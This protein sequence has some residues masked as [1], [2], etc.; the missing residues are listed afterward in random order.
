MKAA[1]LL[2]EGDHLV[3]TEGKPV[4]VKSITREKA[5]REV[6][7]FAVSANDQNMAEHIIAAEGVL[8]GDLVWQGSLSDEEK[9][10]KLR[11]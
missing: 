9:A 4:L 7:N 8:V 1:R 3:S 2:K 10:L 11:E 6:V 5:E